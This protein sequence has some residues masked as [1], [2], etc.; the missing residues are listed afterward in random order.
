M[1]DDEPQNV[2]RSALDRHIGSRMRKRRLELGITE[3]P[4]CQAMDIDAATLSAWEEGDMSIPPLQLLE[5]AQLLNC[6]LGDLYDGFSGA[7]LSDYPA[8]Q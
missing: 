2:V 1:P 8:I 7:G 3:H 6:A 5:A 4:F